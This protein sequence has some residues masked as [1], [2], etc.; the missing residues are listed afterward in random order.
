MYSRNSGSGSLC[1]LTHVGCRFL[2]GL[3]ALRGLQHEAHPFSGA[4][5]SHVMITQPFH[6][7][8]NSLSV[9]RTELL[10]HPATPAASCRGAGLAGFV[11][12]RTMAGK[13]ACLLYPAAG[14]YMCVVW[15]S[16]VQGPTQ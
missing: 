5:L 12:H 3:T 13:G 2:P 8:I 1:T 6:I 9:W 11:P 14:A 7:C 15:A 10:A 16:F 4:G